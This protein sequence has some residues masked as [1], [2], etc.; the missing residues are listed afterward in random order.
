[1][2]LFRYDP[3]ACGVRDGGIRA[4]DDDTVLVTDPDQ[5][6][7][8]LIPCHLFQL[9]SNPVERNRRLREAFAYVE[10]M[11]ERHVLADW[12]EHVPPPD[13]PGL[14]YTRAALTPDILH[15]YPTAVAW[16]WPIG[17]GQFGTDL[18][19]RLDAAATVRR[20]FTHDVAF[21]GWRTPNGPTRETCDAALL[22]VRRA[23][24]DRAIVEAFGDFHGHRAADAETQRREILYTD[25][26]AA[27]PLQLAPASAPGILRYRVF[28][29]LRAGRIPVIIDGPV[30][31]PRADVVPWDDVS[32]HIHGRDAADAGTVLQE[33]LAEEPAGRLAERCAMA[34][35]AWLRAFDSRREHELLAEACRAHVLEKVGAR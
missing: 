19:E 28:E 18:G 9:G 29:A 20:D 8:F 24:G 33:W 1:M 31:L 26:V 25:G 15:R 10:A 11:P 22:S 7:V 35:A 34:R 3:E 32:I 13:L 4:R 12:V 5:A 21:V 23:F 27:A 14:V 6:D 2:K 30:I 16:H 17:S